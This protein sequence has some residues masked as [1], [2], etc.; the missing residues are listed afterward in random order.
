ML[1]MSVLRALADVLIR[2]LRRLGTGLR[3]VTR[4]TY[5]QRSLGAAATPHLSGL[6]D[7]QAVV[8]AADLALIA[9]LIVAPG[10]PQLWHLLLIVVVVV[11]T[12]VATLL[13]PGRLGAGLTLAGQGIWTVLTA[14]WLHSE[15]VALLL[16]PGFALVVQLLLIVM[17]SRERVGWGPW[18][19][20]TTAGLLLG[21][22]SGGGGLLVGLI[23]PS[24]PLWISAIL[25]T[26]AAVMTVKLPKPAP[27]MPKNVIPGQVVQRRD[28]SYTT[29]RPS[30][31]DDQQR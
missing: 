11:T 8:V 22:F 21:I 19:R 25:L 2:V 4:Q 7:L 29:Y 24:F 12:A 14:Q 15:W 27:P 1:S 6:L 31:L 13:K 23:A 18:L 10:G 17:W 26:A 3:W 20:A 16:L 28:D 30:S 5:R 9:G